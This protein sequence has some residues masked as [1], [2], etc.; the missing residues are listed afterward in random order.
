MINYLFSSILLPLV[1]GLIMF[2]MGLSLTIKDFK[3]IFLYPKSIVIGLSLQMLFLP[4]IA[5][6]LALLSPLSA[7]FKVGIVII[8]ACP[9]GTVS[10]LITYLFRGNVALSIALTTVNSLLT[11]FTIPIIVN[12]ALWYFMDNTSDIT[13]PFSETFWQ[14]L[15]ITLLPC[16]LG[17][18]VNFNFPKFAFKMSKILNYVMPTA[19]A[20][21]MLGT[22]YFGQKNE[23]DL[24]FNDYLHISP[25]VIILNI[26]GMLLGYYITGGFHLKRKNR[27]T[28][29]VEVGL[30]NTGLALNVASN[31]KLLNNPL[32]ATPASIY[33]LFTFFT[34][35]AMGFIFGNWKRQSKQEV[36]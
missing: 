9:G 17:I 32:M 6:L 25:F 34:A 31:A 18:W 20:L 27:F 11:I 4:L 13:L 19:L 12:I 1:L 29:S 23:V 21:A 14:I 26:A 24:H 3:N 10:N 33:A 28:I 15:T 35:L 30:Q 2:G 8:S 22:V 5:F 16:A 36:N 7:E